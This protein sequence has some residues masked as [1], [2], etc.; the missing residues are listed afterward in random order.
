M[1]FIL[2]IKMSYVKIL[3]DDYIYDDGDI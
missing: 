2:F 1:S 3:R